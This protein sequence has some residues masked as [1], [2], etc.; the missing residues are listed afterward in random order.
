M[1]H[2][3]IQRPAVSPAG[4]PRDWA[5][6]VLTGLAR[7]RQR[8]PPAVGSPAPASGAPQGA[9]CSVGARIERC[10]HVVFLQSRRLPLDGAAKNSGRA[11]ARPL[12]GHSPALTM[13]ASTR[14]RRR[15]RALPLPPPESL[16]PIHAYGPSREAR[17]RAPPQAG[18][19]RLPPRP[20]HGAVL[21]P[22]ECAVQL[23]SQT[24]AVRK[25]STH[26]IEEGPTTLDIQR[27]AA[28]TPH[29]ARATQYGCSPCAAWVK[30]AA[31]RLAR[32]PAS[33][34]ARG[35]ATARRTAGGGPQRSLWA[36]Q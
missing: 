25:Q 11:A 17:A 23:A 18:G 14:V 36:L 2:L 24:A 4:R 5:T 7:A 22:R 29:G 10:A 1:G 8:M 15:T 9:Q 27:R 19:T 31:A 20:L 30:A 3:G 33:R 35:V 16:Q 28:P 34:G 6:P 13:A 32:P 26:P 12:N 21:P